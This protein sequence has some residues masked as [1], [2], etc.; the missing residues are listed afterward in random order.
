M[1]KSQGLLY[2]LGLMI[3]GIMLESPIL[4]ICTLIGTICYSIM[5]NNRKL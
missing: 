3:L 2:G 1:D 5:P 4:M